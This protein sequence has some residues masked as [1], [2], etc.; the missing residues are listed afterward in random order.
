M[1]TNISYRKMPDSFLDTYDLKKLEMV[2][3]KS[4]AY[5]ISGETRIKIPEAPAMVSLDSLCD[6]VMYLSER[7]E[8][9]NEAERKTFIVVAE[10]INRFYKEGYFERVQGFPSCFSWIYACDP[11]GIM[12]CSC[13][14]LSLLHTVNLGKRLE[15]EQA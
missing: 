10:R 15:R 14:S 7:P 6:R 9:W 4:T 8:E 1:A 5:Y 12:C 11:C 13:P 3:P 2:L